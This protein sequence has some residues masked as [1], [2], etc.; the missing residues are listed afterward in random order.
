MA[1]GTGNSKMKGLVTVLPKLPTLQLVCIECT[2]E[3]QRKALPTKAKEIGG[4]GGA[5]GH[6]FPLKDE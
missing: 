4:G 1:M 6:S 2:V 5:R 3:H